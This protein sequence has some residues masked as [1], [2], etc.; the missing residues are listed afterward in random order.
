MG[1]SELQQTMETSAK[2]RKDQ[3]GRVF[4]DDSW[5]IPLANNMMILNMSDVSSN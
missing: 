5:E 1:Y 3:S 2:H 4:R